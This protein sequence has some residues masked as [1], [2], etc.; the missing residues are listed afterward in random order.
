MKVQKTVAIFHHNPT[1][2]FKQAICV[3][4][5]LHYLHQFCFSTKSGRWPTLSYCIS[6]LS[7]VVFLLPFF[8][9]H[10]FYL[11][12]IYLFSLESSVTAI[13]IDI[14][15]IENQEAVRYFSLECLFVLHIVCKSA[16][17]SQLTVLM[18]SILY[19]YTKKQRKFC[20]NLWRK[21]KKEHFE[22]INVKDINDNK[23]SERQ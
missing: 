9:V 23:N 15:A 19:A 2:H 13:V 18:N 4:L 6:S 3:Y 8:Q 1:L 7:I 11:L 17:H 14:N 10:K 22:N 12:M 21:I 20:V 5:Y 16:S